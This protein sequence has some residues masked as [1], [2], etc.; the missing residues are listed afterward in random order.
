[1]AETKTKD[2]MEYDDLAAYEEQEEMQPE[3]KE[4]PEQKKF[5]F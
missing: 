1:M 4:A 5:V 3:K 2:A